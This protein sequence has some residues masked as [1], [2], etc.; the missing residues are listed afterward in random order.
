MG[1]FQSLQVDASSPGTQ[2]RV[3]DLQFYQL[4][5]QQATKPDFQKTATTRRSISCKPGWG[6]EDVWFYPRRQGA[7]RSLV[8]E[9]FALMES[10]SSLGA[11]QMT[12][13][14]PLGSL[15]ACESRLRFAAK[16]VDLRGCAHGQVLVE[17]LMSGDLQQSW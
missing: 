2:F 12:E 15:M 14:T 17:K 10:I 5:V 8:L 1:L 13:S 11:L 6:Y 16:G 9:M 4:T 3:P 7:G